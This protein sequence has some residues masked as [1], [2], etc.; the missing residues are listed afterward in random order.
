MQKSCLC[1]YSDP[2][3]LAKGNISIESQRGDNVNNGEKEVVF[4]NCDPFTDCISKINNTQIDNNKDIDVV[5]TEKTSLIN[6]LKVIRERMI[7]F[8]KFQAAINSAL[9][10]FKQKITGKIAANGLKG[11]E[12]MVP[13]KD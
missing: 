7:T 4:K 1:D 9:F 8:G 13:V 6:Q 3:I 5:M 11:V 12:I 10:K 2:Y